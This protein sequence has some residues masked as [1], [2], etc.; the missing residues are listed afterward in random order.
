MSELPRPVVERVGAALLAGR[1]AAYVVI[2][3]AHLI[4]ESGGPLAAHGLGDVRPGAPAAEQLPVLHGLL[5]LEEA[6]LVLPDV[7][8]T[9]GR[10][11]TVRLFRHDGLVWAVFTDATREALER[12]TA[13]QH[14]NALSLVRS[15]LENLE[16][17]IEQELEAAAGDVGLRDALRALDTAV[18]ELRDDGAF[19]VL[20][21]P[22][23]QWFEELCGN[24]AP[25]ERSDFLR[26]FVREAG[27][28]W[29]QRAGERLSSGMWTETFRSGDDVH[30]EATA[31]RVGKRR[32]LVVARTDTE[33]RDRH[34]LL[35]TARE[36]KLATA[37]RITEE[38]R[39]AE[40]FRAH[41]DDL[42]RLVAE[43]TS[44]L[45]ETNRQL[46]REIAER[47][48]ATERLI[49]YQARLRSLAREL[50]RAEEQERRRIAVGLHDHIGQIL[51][52]TKIKLGGLRQ[53]CAGTDLAGPLDDVYALLDEVIDY[54]RSL[55]FELASPVLYELGLE[56]ALEELAEQG[57]KR[58]A[59]RTTFR[60]DGRPKPVDEETR[61]IL[62]Q[63]VRE[64]LFNVSK[65]AGAST[66]SI[67]V[68]RSDDTLRIDVSDDGAG[69]PESRSEPHAPSAG[70]FGLFNIREQLDHLGGRMDISS[71]PGG[72]SRVTLLAPLAEGTD[73]K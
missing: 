20:G 63:A 10:F 19:D 69:F 3:E 65:H 7:T 38:T 18:I 27:D 71:P 36:G 37:R 70:G 21:A 56:A 15:Q 54:S 34:R 32:V 39:R 58:Y 40:K 13:R 66:V 60:D 23:P 25:W 28:F 72:G 35:Q 16:L 61:L 11:S 43:R 51:A 50:A 41:R 73:E 59:V 46:R 22:P 53:T 47:Q 57:E 52:L 49:A 44:E 64:L 62:Y 30:L 31:L 4:V 17:R 33:Y 2:D 55:T 45:T 67:E 42:E 5:P 14:R 6:D 9:E 8:M 12:Q 26:D 24:A 29:E 68:R 1:D 48:R